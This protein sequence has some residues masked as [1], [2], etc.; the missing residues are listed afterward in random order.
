MVKIVDMKIYRKIYFNFLAIMCVMIAAVYLL[1]KN[2]IYLG[3]FFIQSKTI[4]YGFLALMLAVTF[5]YSLY[6]RRQREKLQA[7]ADFDKKLA[8]HQNYFKTRMWWQILGGATS[9][10]LYMITA[11]R[12]FFWFALF[13]LLSLVVV[14]PNKFFFKKELNDEDIIFL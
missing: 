2:G 11:H 8:F 7:I 9:C 6:L 4:V 1:V 12:Y 10:I 3:Q 5:V 13:D 14:F